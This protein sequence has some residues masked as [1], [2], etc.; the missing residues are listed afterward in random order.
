[1]KRYCFLIIITSLIIFSA[2]PA[3][4]RASSLAS[5]EKIYDNPY[6]EDGVA[7]V[8]LIGISRKKTAAFVIKFNRN[9]KF[10]S[11]GYFIIDTVSK[12]ILED[13][14]DMY[15][16]SIYSEYDLFQKITPLLIK[17]GID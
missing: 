11:Y 14:S 15:T 9:R 5:S 13:N 1:M 17:Y 4:S 8:Y 2:G 16:S 6:V 12:K 7:A 10:S 3:F